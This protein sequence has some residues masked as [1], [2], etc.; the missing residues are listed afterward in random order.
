MNPQGA[1][2]RPAVMTPH[3]RAPQLDEV[4]RSLREILGPGIK[5]QLRDAPFV[6][7][8]LATMCARVPTDGIRDSV[9]GSARG[10]IS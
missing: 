7:E 4:V 3:E 10:W 8:G 1:A 6:A 9:N 2:P 5:F